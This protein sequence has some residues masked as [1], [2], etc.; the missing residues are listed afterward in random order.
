MTNAE[1][2][3]EAKRLGR[4]GYSGKKKEQIIEII[5]NPNGVKS[6]RGRPKGS[7]VGRPKQQGMSRAKTVEY[8]Q[9]G[10]ND[11]TLPI[12]KQLSQQKGVTGYT[13]KNKEDIVKMLLERGHQ[14][15][16]VIQES[17]EGVNNMV[18]VLPTDRSRT[19]P[20]QAVVQQT[21]TQAQKSPRSQGQVAQKDLRIVGTMM[22]I[23]MPLPTYQ[24]QQSA[25]VMQMPTA[26][27]RVSPSGRRY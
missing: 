21:Q 25:G 15:S 9:A 2:I 8:S 24:V 11:L 22:Q 18:T 12:L 16:L 7:G 4:S 19:L 3:V 20:M 5:M 13:G 10:L 26:Q 1:L 14:E 17:K 6:P 23:P 27:G